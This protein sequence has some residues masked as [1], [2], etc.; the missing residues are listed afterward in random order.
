M[1]FFLADARNNTPIAAGTDG[2]GDTHPAVT[3]RA[4]K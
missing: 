4:T 3:G 1:F 2:D